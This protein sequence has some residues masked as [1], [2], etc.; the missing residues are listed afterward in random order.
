MAAL[1]VLP[2]QHYVGAVESMPL[3]VDLIEI[4]CDAKP[5]IQST[6]ASSRTC[7]SHRRVTEFGSLAHLSRMRLLRFCRARR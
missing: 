1:N 4:D 2:P 6:T 3:I 7:T 5:S